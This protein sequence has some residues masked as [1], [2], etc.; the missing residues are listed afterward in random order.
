MKRFIDLT[1]QTFGRWEVIEFS[2]IGKGRLA[3]WACEC[4]CEKKTIKIVSGSSLRNGSS[5]S[6]E[7]L[8]SEIAKQVM[9]NNMKKYN[10]YDLSK[11]YGIGYDENG[12][13]F[14]FDLE[15]YD[16]IKNYYWYVNKRGYVC[17]YIAPGGK[18]I[19]LHRLIL[20][21]KT[22]STDH[23]NRNKADCR[24]E[25][26]VPCTQT[27]NC[28]N[29]SLSKNNTSGVTGVCWDKSKNKWVARLE[30]EGKIKLF[31][32]F[33]KKEDAIKA[34]LEA[35]IKYFKQF[36]CHEKLYKQYGLIKEESNE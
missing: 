12:N 22:P 21:N 34:R 2:H 18:Y 19:L 35:E 28:K 30:N 27:D 9:R 1:G 14:L 8:H 31:K 23:H 15:D 36:A 32:R 29:K 5:K 25:N 26:L 24:K 17:A 13:S 7:C 3:Y 10:T 11:D 20:N 4:Q 33:D 6:C 16:K